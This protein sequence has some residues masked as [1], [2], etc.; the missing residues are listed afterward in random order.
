MH[1]TSD[2]KRKFLA[3]PSWHKTVFSGLDGGFDAIEQE[4]LCEALKA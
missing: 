3:G 4:Q 1:Y 2:F